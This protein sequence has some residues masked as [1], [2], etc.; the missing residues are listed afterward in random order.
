MRVIMKGRQPMRYLKITIVAAS[1]AAT[2]INAD[3]F[4]LRGYVMGTGGTP[5]TGI[6]SAG[7]TMYGTVGQS[8]VGV[9][10]AT[11]TV[12]DGFW[13]FGGVRVLA[14]EPLETPGLP[15]QVSFSAPR[16]NPARDRVGFELALP[17]E[18]SVILTIFDVH[19]RNV[20]TMLDRRLAAGRY[21]V[22]WDGLDGGGAGGAGIYF[23]RLQVDG[24]PVA[25]QRIV[26][27]R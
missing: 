22:Q 18:A 1:L 6:T 24:R 4:S 25:T 19:G 14:V 8:V 2:A 12:C 17:G 16:P 27:L 15:T 10:S 11:R 23:A 3:A 26:M 13:C 9:S 21:R 7:R 5:A 20:L